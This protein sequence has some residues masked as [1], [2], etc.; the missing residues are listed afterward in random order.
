MK[1]TMLTTLSLL[2]FALTTYFPLAFSYI[3]QLEDING[4]PIFYST[5]FYIM[6][7]IFGAAGGGLKLG[8]T[9][10]STCPLTVLQDYSEVIN[11]L[12]LKF[13]PPG[14][15]F[16]DL[17]STDKLLAG[18]EFVEKPACAES[19]KWVVVEDDDIPRPYVG[20]GGIEDNKGKRIKNGNFIIVK[21]GFGYKIMFC[22]QFN[23]PPPGLCFDIG[24]YKDDENGR[25]L[26]LTENDPFEIVF[27]IPERSVA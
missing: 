25:H 3:E 24:R 8:K 20:I 16:V 9:G 26:I 12:E 21:H 7:S 17:I 14:E 10:N 6:P 15:I 23:A 22:P 4:N 11:G 5:H 18:I 2:L 1:P 19:S 13:T 27:V